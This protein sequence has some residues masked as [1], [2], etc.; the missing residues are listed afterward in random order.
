[1]K[2]KSIVKIWKVLRAYCITCQHYTF[3]NGCVGGCFNPPRDC[4]SALSSCCGH[5]RITT[6]WTKFVLGTL[7]R[8][9]ERAYHSNQ[10]KLE[11]KEGTKHDNE[12]S[13]HD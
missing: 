5:Y 13:A 8:W 4:L 9:S 7:L 11:E 3:W 6:H 10:I 2:I 12:E 1:M